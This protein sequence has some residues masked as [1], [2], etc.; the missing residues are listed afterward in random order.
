[1]TTTKRSQKRWFGLGAVIVLAAVGLFWP[2]DG[3]IEQPGGADKLA[4]F[5]KIQDH[6][7]NDKGAYRITSVQFTKANHLSYLMAQ[8]NPHA[9]YAKSEDVTAGQDTATFARIQSFYMQSA[10]ANAQRVAYKAA[11]EDVSLSYRGIYVLN[12]TEQSHFKDELAVGDTITEIDG[13]HFDNSD[14]Y[15][16]YLADKK[17]GTDVEI[18]Y[19]RDGQTH[20]AKGKTIK[21]PNTAS[22]K[23]PNGRHGIGVGLT[24]DVTVTTNPKISVDPGRIGGP[25]GGLMFSLQMY[26]Q[27]TTEN[28]RDGRD[29]AG[30]GT[31]DAQGHVGEIGGIDKKIIAAKE[32]GATIFLTPYVEPSPE[33][34][35]EQ[36]DYQTNY[37][38]AV[39]TAKKYAPEMTIVP[40]RT[41]DD[42]VAY[43]KTGQVITT[44][45]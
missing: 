1:M 44:K 29:I 12:V 15:I 16:D 34:L 11:G 24:D 18:T 8:V 33:L 13:H 27:L 45:D 28:L 32:A 3:Y 4:N 42:A 2:M 36:P 10:I 21:L 39:Q 40:V 30:S 41:F 31:I 38:L 17:T 25:S 20:Q 37:Q 19:E 9:Q 5:V 35:K 14:G 26:D 7:D 6:P 43:L 22:A 23:Y